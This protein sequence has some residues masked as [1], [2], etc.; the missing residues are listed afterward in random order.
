MKFKRPIF[1]TYG[2]IEIFWLIFCALFT[3]I[4]FKNCKL[5]RLPLFIRGKDSVVFG[6]GF[7]C[8]YFNRID[9]YG[10]KGCIRFG[11]NVQINDFNHFGAVNSIVFGDDVLIASK[12][13]ISD[14]SHGEYSDTLN[15]S[16]PVELPAKRVEPYGPVNIG[17]RVWIGEGAAILPGV[18]IGHGA[19]IGAGAV[20]TKNIPPDSMAVGVPARVIKKYNHQ[21]NSWERVFA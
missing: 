18:T 16:S 5:I 15:S 13:F 2:F 14:H 8:G 20:V 17:D 6:K 1:K 12:V 21:L 9:A 4:F 3:L 11:K 19:V 10:P 7:V